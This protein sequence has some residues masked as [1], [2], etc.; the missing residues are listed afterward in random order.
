MDFYHSSV[1]DK[2]VIQMISNAITYYVSTYGKQTVSKYDSHKSNELRDVY[3]NMLKIN[4]KS[5]LYKFP[6]SDS[7]QKY[8]IDLK[9]AAHSIKNVAASMTNEDG[10]ISGFSKKK[11][12]SSNRKV[13]DAKYI[14]DLA[15]AEED[16]PKDISLFVSK[17]AKPQVNLG[18]YLKK[19]SLDILKGPYSFDLSI[20]EYTYE[21]QFNVK[22]DDTNLKIQERLARLIN[23]S[24]IDLHA[25]IDEDSDGLTALKLTSDN[26]GVPSYK[27]LTFTIS[28]SEGIENGNAVEYFGLSNVY[29]PPEN[30]EFTI[31][32]TPKTSVSNTISIN[33]QFEVTLKGISIE[34]DETIIGLKPDFD[35]LTENISEFIDTYNSMIDL[36]KERMTGTYES[37][38]FYRDISGIAKNYKNY[39]D[40]SGFTVLSDGKL[41]LEESLL[42]QSANEGTLNDSLDKLNNFKNSLIRKS[43]NI[44]LNPMQYIDKKM[45]SYPHPT[46]NMPSPY[47]TSIYSGMMFNGYI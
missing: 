14:G 24:N 8:A 31:N 27:N 33:G 20:G 46:R 41:K 21:F 38:M 18:N 10:S 29:S 2:E 43:D 30:A 11:A 32:G 5:P 23:R 4:K 45:I 42:I 3:N 9:E 22:S 28:D 35:A 44:S 1:L 40:S 7:I 15:D 37:G 34:D 39:L 19:D 12:T 13:A 16:S 17:L 25:E 36:A 26:T 6:S 47:V